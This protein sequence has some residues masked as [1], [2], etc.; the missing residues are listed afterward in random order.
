[1]LD[2]SAVNEIRPSKLRFTADVKLTPTI[3]PANEVC[4]STDIDVSVGVTAIS[5]VL[6]VCLSHKCLLVTLAPEIGTVKVVPLVWASQ[7]SSTGYSTP[8]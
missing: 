3:S 5:V 7:S 4:R 8:V 2:I 1:M 6:K